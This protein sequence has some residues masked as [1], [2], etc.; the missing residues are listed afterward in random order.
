MIDRCYRVL[1]FHATQVTSIPTAVTGHHIT[2]QVFS[3][4]I[5]GPDARLTSSSICPG[6]SVKQ[7]SY[8]IFRV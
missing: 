6:E 7:H 2:P 1:R 4:D 5:L 3:P 8:Q